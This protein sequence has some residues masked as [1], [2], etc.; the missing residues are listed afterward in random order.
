[1]KPPGWYELVKPSGQFVVVVQRFLPCDI[2][3]FKYIKMINYILPK[4]G[5]KTLAHSPGEHE[6]SLGFA[7][8]AINPA[9]AS[10][11]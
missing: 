2:Q 7:A 9:S 8:A 3:A 10:K 5:S 11:A 6:Q 1:V 4:V